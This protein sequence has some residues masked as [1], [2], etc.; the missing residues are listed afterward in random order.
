MRVVDQRKN[1]GWEA[2]ASV[3]GEEVEKTPSWGG[4]VGRR[5]ASVEGHLVTEMKAGGWRRMGE[6]GRVG[7]RVCFKYDGDWC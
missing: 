4:R 2:D 5:D 3:R 7:I 6:R 1:E